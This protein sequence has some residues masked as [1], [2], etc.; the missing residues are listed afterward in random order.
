MKVLII[1]LLVLTFIFAICNASALIWSGGGGNTT[2]FYNMTAN[3]TDYAKYQFTN[4]NFNGSGNFTTTGSGT[5]SWI[6]KLA[7]DN[8]PSTPPLYTLRLW[9]DYDAVSGY[10]TYRYKDDTA[11]VR[12][13]ADNVFIGKN[14]GALLI[15]KGSVVYS[16]GSSGLGAYPLLCLAKADNLSTMPSI[17]IT[18]ENVTVGGYGRVMSIGVLENVNTNSFNSNAPLYVSDSIAGSLTM[19]KPLT[20]NMTQEIGTVLVKSATA[21]KI[22]LVARS[23]TGNEFGTINNFIVQ[24]NLSALGSYHNLIGIIN[25]SAGDLYVRNI[26]VS[27]WLYNQTQSAYFY[28]MT[29][30]PYFYNMSS[31]SGW[32]DGGTNVYLVTSTDK[33]GIGT[34]APLQPLHVYLG[35]STRTYALNY[36]GGMIIEDDDDSVLRF[37]TPESKSQEIWFGDNASESSGR[38]RYEHAGDNMTFWTGGG[39]KMKIDSA[40]NVGIGTTS[41]THTLN[42]VGTSNFT[43]NA[44]FGQNITIIA[45]GA[46]PTNSL[47]LAD[48]SDTVNAQYN[49]SILTF[50]TQSVSTAAIS[51]KFNIQGIGRT[52]VL[53]PNPYLKFFVT[54]GDTAD[55][56]LIIAHDGRI[57]I[58]VIEPSYLLEIKKSTTSLNVSGILYV[59]S[60]N[61]GIGTSTST[62]TLRVVGTFNATSNVYIGSNLYVAQNITMPGKFTGSSVDISNNYQLCFLNYGDSPNAMCLKASTTNATFLTF[63]NNIFAFQSANDQDVRFWNST[64]QTFVSFKPINGRVGIGTTTP[65]TELNVRGRLNVTNTLTVD[66]TGDG[67]IGWSIVAQANTACSTTCISA[68]VAGFADGL[69]GSTPVLC[70]DATA[71]RCLCA[72]AS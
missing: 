37:L 41:P 11:M 38:I 64:G 28:N 45:D 57:G 10:S 35:N 14:T 54:G 43:Q 12:R 46:A 20:P 56:S 7:Q 33:V 52:V 19:A 31:T 21:G 16:C 44:I 15:P 5:F 67:T 42:V 6:D 49:S 61:V 69:G 65:V 17:G 18:I 30:S 66:G 27:T 60:T 9:V 59:N 25:I 68:C 48:L 22:E 72:G 71:D 23:L 32:N 53:T 47:I 4:N 63:Y 3:L 40:G 50:D 8:P 29:Q 24:G 13:I 58:G 2:Y 1:F 39:Q 55:N 26:N 62:D 36:R 70:S 51:T 34:I